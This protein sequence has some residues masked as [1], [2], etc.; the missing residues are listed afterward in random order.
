V[1]SNDSQN[2]SKDGQIRSGRLVGK[3]LPLMIWILAMPALIQQFMAALVGL[4]DKILAGALPESIVVA[5]LDGLGVGSYVGWLIGIAMAGIGIGGQALIAR[6]MGSGDSDQSHSALGQALSI[7][8]A[9]G[10]LFGAAM[11]FLAP[12]LADLA[13]LDEQQQ[14]RVFC[15]QYVRIIACGL[16]FFGIMMVGGMCMHGAGESLVP[17]VIAVL[18]NVVNVVCSWLLSGADLA[19]LGLE[20]VTSPLGLDLHVAGI[21]WGSTI[22]FACG[23]LLT[24]LALTRGIKDLQLHWHRLRFQSQMAWRVVRIGIPNF[25]E[26]LSMW[27]ANLVVLWFI[28]MVASFEIARDV[29]AGSSDD[30]TE[31]AEAGQGLQGAHIIAVQWEA[32]SFMPGFAIGIAAGAIAGQF[33]GAGNLAMARKAVWTCVGIGVVIM[34]LMGLVFTFFG[35]ALT[36][37]ISDEPVYME[38]VPKLLIICGVT[39]VFFAISMVTRQALRGVGDTTW[40]FIITTCSSYLVRLPAAWLFG[41]KLEMGLVG[42][43]IALCGELVVR[44]MLFLARFVHG[45]WAKREL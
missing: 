14:A 20:G 11:W 22:S 43:W 7:S 9:W 35:S 34:G 37:V 21:A 26:G 31:L 15:I 18:V 40:V 3:S 42:I 16:P 8:F 24:V 10:M 2:K 39:Q 4:F 33:L 25:F 12:L 19:W 13:L 28:G 17:S 1:S 38:T 41:V 32:F 36:S 29:L 44:S 45:G 30:S 27:M 6:A 23:A 5:S